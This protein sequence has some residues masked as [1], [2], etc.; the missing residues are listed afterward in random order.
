MSNAVTVPADK[1]AELQ[2][3]AKLA[4][5]LEKENAELKAL[6]HNGIRVK[7]S[8][9]ESKLYDEIHVWY[10]EGANGTLILWNKGD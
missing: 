1:L 9:T 3:K 10:G 6:I 2:H 5:E 4:D 8:S 7:V